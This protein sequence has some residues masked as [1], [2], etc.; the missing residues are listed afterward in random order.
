MM[1]NALLA[2]VLLAPGC[3]APTTRCL[4]ATRVVCTELCVDLA[5]DEAN[6]GV[7]G[8]RCATGS[9]CTSGT[10]GTASP[11]RDGGADAPPV[12]ECGTCESTADC[13]AGLECYPRLCDG[14]RI[15]AT[16]SSTCLVTGGDPPCPT[17]W[18]WQACSG[19]GGD[20]GC[21]PL[22]DC[23]RVNDFRQG[24]RRRCTTV[25]DCSPP[26]GYLDYEQACISGHCR[27]RCDDGAS[28][29]PSAECGY[30]EPDVCW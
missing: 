2:L 22:S 20:P 12:R 14:I 15:C 11:M 8:N 1:R 24:C 21:G 27:L 28:C 7:C 29:P 26:L 18:D 25:D 9:T 30:V 13:A 10:C 16:G 23:V 5:T 19:E 6:C 17:T 4:D 3:P